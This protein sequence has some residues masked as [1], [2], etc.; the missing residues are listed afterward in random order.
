MTVAELIR[1]LES[2]PQDVHVFAEG[3]PAD[4]VIFEKSPDGNGGIVRIFKVWDVEFVDGFIP[5]ESEGV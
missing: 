1:E 2:M 3:K 4:K 5:R